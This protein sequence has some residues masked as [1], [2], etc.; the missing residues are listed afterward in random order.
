MTGSA[1]ASTEQKDKAFTGQV[2]VGYL[3]DNGLTPYASYA[4]SF[5]VNVGQTPSGE[6][7][8]PSKGKQYEVGVKYEPTFF[9]G[10]SPPRFSTCAR[11]T[12]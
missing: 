3:F 8:V 1:A 6:T 2:G 11:P 10:Y 12:Y 5:T 4:E 9:P 7:F